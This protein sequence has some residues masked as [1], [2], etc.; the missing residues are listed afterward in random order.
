MRRIASLLLF[1]FVLI[2]SINPVSALTYPPIYVPGAD[3]YVLMDAKSGQILASYQANKQVY[4]ASTTKMLTAVVALENGDLDMEMTATQIAVSDI[5]KDGMN[6]GIQAGEVIRMEDLLHAMLIVSANE[7]ANIIA[8]NICET[9]EAFMNLCNQKASEIGMEN[10]NFTN[11]CGM[12]N[13]NHYTTAMDLGMLACYAMKNETFR[14]IVKKTSFK[15]PV[16]NKHSTWNTMYTSN[17]LLKS[18]NFNGYEIIGIKSGY[19]DP[20]GRC[21]ITGAKNNDGEELIVVV[22][23]VRDGNSGEII[24][25][26]STKLLEHGFKN[27]QNINLIH[28]DVFLGLQQIDNARDNTPLVLVAQDDLEAFTLATVD[29]EKIEIK[30]NINDWL[31]LPV[32]QNDL[33]GTADFYYYNQCLGTVNVVAGNNVYSDLSGSKTNTDKPG[34]TGETLD[35][36]SNDNNENTNGNGNKILRILLQ[37]GKIILIVIAVFVPTYLLLALIVNVKKRKRFGKRR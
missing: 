1:I 29:T 14:S 32:K 33:V 18:N 11:P 17:I 20:A 4:P 30:L 21:L 19:T 31:T 15:M 25:N 23:G 6:I 5:G 10:T 22:M 16:T 3:A 8:E 35:E 12:H 13:E 26:I 37:V 24:T 2:F 34:N 36:D 9:R 28:K 27:F 7:T